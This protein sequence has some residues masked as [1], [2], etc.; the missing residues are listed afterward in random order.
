MIPNAFFGALFPALASLA[1][2]PA[3]LRRTFSRVMWALGAFGAAAA[4]AAYLT[5]PTLVGITYGELFAP[6]ATILSIL[7]LS[8]AF[9]LL[10]GGRTLY[11]Y[12]LGREQQV[13]W[14]NGIVIVFQ[15]ALSLWLIPTLGAAGAAW[16][17]VAV[18]AAGLLLL[19]RDLRLPNMGRLRVDRSQT[20]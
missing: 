4:L 6:A 9:S 3:V 5:A 19:W 20:A 10:R 13:N 16:A 2:Q 7:M 17:L 1:A 15:A 8:M 18:E 14:V 12:A 11:W